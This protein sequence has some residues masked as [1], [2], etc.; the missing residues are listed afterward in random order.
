MPRGF[1]PRAGDPYN[2]ITMTQIQVVARPDAVT[3]FPPRPSETP[4]RLDQ[5]ELVKLAAEGPLARIYRA[6]AAGAAGEGPPPYALK[7]LRPEHEDDARAVGL[8]SREARVG[9][10]VAHPHLISHLASHVSRPPYYV[11]MPWLEGATL[12][13]YLAGSASLDLPV[14]LWTV[15]QVAEA[16]DALHQAGWRHGD[17][18]P[19]NIFISPQ[20]HVTL[21][22][23]GF[24]RRDREPA[25]AAERFIAGTVNYLAPE[26]ITSTL[27]AD[28]RGDLYSL[29]VVLFELLAGRLPFE[30][31]DLAELA[32]RHQ[33]C[34]VP[35]LRTLAPHLPAG[36]IRL[37]RQL[38]AKEPLRRPR[39]P[40]ELVDRLVT[41][42]IESFGQRALD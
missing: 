39:T 37:V 31:R 9:R 1:R 5:W 28:I 38:L 19:S 16:L 2:Q 6:R 7:L 23:L 35:D 10:N 22:D 14:I 41:L 21:L 11:V 4:R 24:A 30:G 20:W 32:T 26:L 36:V 15:R 3:A 25:S 12:S 29:G 34:R 13:A 33:T 42:E 17:V 40:G 18:K 8:F 27:R